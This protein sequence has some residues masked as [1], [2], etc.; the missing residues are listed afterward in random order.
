M[1]GTIPVWVI[2]GYLG[3]GKTTLLNALLRDAHGV[4]FAVLVNDFGSVNVDADLIAASGAETLELTNGCTCCTIGGDLILALKQLA[5]RNVPPERIVIEA[6]GVGDPRA[7]A[8]LAAAH[9]TLTVVGA[10]VVVDAESIRERVKDKYVGGLVRRQLHAADAVVLSKVDVID[11]RELAGLR[12]WIGAT[13]PGVPVFEAIKGAGF[14][15]EIA[16]DSDFVTRRREDEPALEDGPHTDFIATTFRTAQPV[17]RARFLA[18]AA[19]MPAAITRAKGIVYFADEPE[20][21]YLFQLAGERWSIEPSDALEP[22]R[23]TRIVAIAPAEREPG[24]KQAV[25]ALAHAAEIA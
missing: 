13:I 17:D 9:P 5:A 2:G 25:D 3:S 8:R 20:T 1:N 14:P 21:R 18:A 4:R 15:A 10:I 19:T 12:T 16:F 7:V 11:A 22:A 24:L 23:E 6:S